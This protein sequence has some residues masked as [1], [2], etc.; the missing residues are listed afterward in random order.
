MYRSTKHR[1]FVLFALV[2]VL[3]LV[4]VGKHIESRYLKR[5]IV[6]HGRTLKFP[7][8]RSAQVEI[9][10]NSTSGELMHEFVHAMRMSG[11]V[12]R[13]VPIA[14]A[15]EFYVD[16]CDGNLKDD[17][18]A[19]IVRKYSRLRNQEKL[20]SR[21]QRLLDANFDQYETLKSYE[22]AAA[23]AGLT[24][25]MYPDKENGIRFLG[26]LGRGFGP[27]ISSK[28]VEDS[29]IQ[30]IVTSSYNPIP[31]SIMEKLWLARS[32]LDSVEVAELVQYIQLL[33]LQSTPNASITSMAFNTI[34]KRLAGNDSVSIYD[35][36][37]ETI[38]GDCESP[39]KVFHHGSH[40]W[41]HNPTIKINK[42]A[43]SGASYAIDSLQ[44]HLHLREISNVIHTQF[45]DSID[46]QIDYFERNKIDSA[47]IYIQWSDLVS[48]DVV[49]AASLCDGYIHGALITINPNT[50]NYYA[51]RQSVRAVLMGYA[52]M[53]SVTAITFDNSS[54][55]Q[56][57]DLYERI[58]G[59]KSLSDRARGYGY[60]EI[61]NALM[62]LGQY[63]LSLEA[64]DLSF[65]LDS[66]N[67][68]LLFSRGMCLYQL[69]QFQNAIQSL[70][71][72][73]PYYEADI[74]SLDSNRVH[75]SANKQLSSFVR[76]VD[77]VTKPIQDK[78]NRARCAV[79][80]SYIQ[81][82]EFE[83]AIAYCDKILRFEDDYHVIWYY[84]GISHL[85]TEDYSAALKCFEHSVDLEPSFIDG[86][87]FIAQSATLLGL[88]R[89]REAAY[90]TAIA[91]C[92]RDSTLADR[93]NT[94]AMMKA[95]KIDEQAGLLKR[96]NEIRMNI[97]PEDD[98]M[99]YFVLPNK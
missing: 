11:Q 74:S 79:A 49:I 66:T 27:R 13:D 29:T 85:R 84:K 58:L 44:Y 90:D 51:V 15:L 2:F 56:T 75:F 18:S 48:S 6:S 62:H 55:L 95:L 24:V 23:L 98:I 10:P 19:R 69:R 87:S 93:K 25:A 68:D 17:I 36:G 39:T 22:D 7:T 40:R 99:N 4:F 91:I 64:L 77:A 82:K 35:Y 92:S 76:E 72:V 30:G 14:A 53:D 97:P 86:W 88:K 21:V 73:I 83:S 67:Y 70:R 71:T 41:A 38:S 96:L 3:T 57:I 1:V 81:L 63:K 47:F 33:V 42:S 52:K 43:R 94:L 12:L 5:V 28:A 50:R 34:R 45:H 59:A 16:Y 78:L 31:F 61:A 37:I 65:S 80:D 46:I 20:V 60:F 26:N 32:K 54:I 8:L 9:S 89:K